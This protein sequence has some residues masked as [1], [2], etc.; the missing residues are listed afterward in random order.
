MITSPKLTDSP[1]EELDETDQLIE[2]VFEPPRSFALSALARNK[3]LV[4]LFAVVLAVIGAGYGGS[5]A[6]TYT[7]SATLQVGQVNPNSPGFYG[8]VQSA[9]SLATAF[10]RAISAEPVL[11]TIQ[12]KLGLAPSVASGRLSSAPIPVAPAFR[13]IATGPTKAAALELANV[14]AEAVIVYEGTSNSGNP[15][16]ESLLHEYREASLQLQQA[17][18]GLA[19]AG[20]GKDASADALARAAADKN[21]AEVRLRAIGNS[22]I[23]AVASQAP[24]SGLVSLLAGATT[25]SNDR[26]SK[27]ELLGF[28]GLLAGIMAGCAAAVLRERRRLARRSP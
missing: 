8:Y 6:K 10:S 15:E 21:A 9:A 27:V 5:R 12:H 25:A 13:V 4:C 20:A 1:P 7:A 24:R 22:Y 17:A 3:P 26:S 16:A 18:I 11:A 14:A 19:H 28:I 23:S 2:G